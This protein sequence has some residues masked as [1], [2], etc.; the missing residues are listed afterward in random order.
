MDL[1]PIATCLLG[2]AGGVGT[3]VISH[4]LKVREAH[5]RDLREAYA[6]WFGAIS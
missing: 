4:R 5:R 2:F 1:F 6:D 3:T